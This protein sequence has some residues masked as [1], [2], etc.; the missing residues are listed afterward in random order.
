MGLNPIGGGLRHIHYDARSAAKVALVVQP[1]DELHVS[2]DVAAQ[3]VAASPQFKDATATA[4]HESSDTPAENLTPPADT[5]APGSKRR[6]SS[7]G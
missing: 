2:D 6:A 4:G 1:G 7:K 5:P 3:L